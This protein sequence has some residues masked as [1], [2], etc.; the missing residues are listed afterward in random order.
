[1]TGADFKMWALIGI[2][3]L[4]FLVVAGGILHLINKNDSNDDAGCSLVFWP[5]LAFYGYF[6][7][8]GWNDKEHVAMLFA[9]PLLPALGCTITTL[10][11]LASAKSWQSGEQKLQNSA[12]GGAILIVGIC[13]FFLGEYADKT[14]KQA[15]NTDLA[16]EVTASAVVPSQPVSSARTEARQPLGRSRDQQNQQYDAMLDQLEAQY[17]PANPRTSSFSPEFVRRLENAISFYERQGMPGPLALQRA[18]TELSGVN[19]VVPMPAEDRRISNPSADAAADAAL[20]AAESA[21]AAA[22]SAANR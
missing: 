10:L 9:S 5:P 2:G 8:R 20:A 7:W 6:L 1:M 21:E 13:A 12:L 4:V 16:P 19:L 18:A 3:Y 14:L 11:V 22:A 17:A 15:A